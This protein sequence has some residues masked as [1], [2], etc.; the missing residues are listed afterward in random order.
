LLVAGRTGQPS[1]VLLGPADPALR[2]KRGSFLAPERLQ[3]SAQI[4]HA[5]DVYA[6]GVLLLE[7]VSGQSFR[8]VLANQKQLTSRMNQLRFIDP[9]LLRQRVRPGLDDDVLVAA[10][11]TLLAMLDMAR[12]CTQVAPSARPACAAVE[13]A[14]STAA[15]QALER[16]SLAGIAVLC[17]VCGEPAAVAALPCGHTCLCEVHGAALLA[18]V[19]QQGTA[20]CSLCTQPCAATRVLWA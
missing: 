14:L 20:A 16:G 2:S 5:S 8:S 12:A 13:A 10:T 11:P 9:A 1:V 4:S 3:G 17:V 6:L 15:C 18:H 7:L 19:R